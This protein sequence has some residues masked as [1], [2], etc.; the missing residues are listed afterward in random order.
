[1]GPRIAIVLLLSALAA[2][3]VW[4]AADARRSSS[5]TARL[6]VRVVDAQGRPLPLARVRVG[7]G[8]WRQVDP[9]GNVTLDLLEPPGP[10]DA[11]AEHVRSLLDVQERTHALLDPEQVPVRATAAGDWEVLLQLEAAGLLRLF[12]ATTHLGMPRAWLPADPGGRWRPVGAQAVARPS[13]PAAWHIRAGVTHVDVRMA[14]EDHPVFG[15]R[16]ATTVHRLPA[17]RPGQ[18]L[19]HRLEPEPRR[20]IRGRLELPPTWGTEPVTGQVEVRQAVQGEWT[21]VAQVQ[22]RPDGTFQV[23]FAGMGR[24]ELAADLNW[25]GRTAPAQVDGGSEVTLLLEHEPVRLDVVLAPAPARPAWIEVRGTGAGQ[26]AARIPLTLDSQGA[27]QLLV[28]GGTRFWVSARV[29]HD[30]HGPERASEEIELDPAGVSQ[31]L[32]LPLQTRGSGRLRVVLDPSAEAS[33][34]GATLHVEGRP[35]RSL[36]RGLGTEQTYEYLPLGNCSLRVEWADASLATLFALVQIEPD[37]TTTFSLTPQAGGHFEALWP[38]RAEEMRPETLEL[39]WEAAGA[40]G[41]APGR[42]T[43]NSLGTGRYR[44]PLA[45]PAGT[46]QGHLRFGLEGEERAVACRFEIRPAE[47]TSLSVDELP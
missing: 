1:M 14:G 17:P 22:L 28:A 21:A 27:G 12:V 30:D 19:E 8:P 4:L 10:S 20:L 35:P 2:V 16:V 7:Q 13:Q 33:F 41:G 5:H 47:T 11:A 31:P 36:L 15:T 6:W 32:V 29:P 43:L 9:D 44:A 45:L 3:A 23:P 18:V 26:A 24:Y 34:R 46:Y 42:L 38:A 40:P 25:R 39:S 37:A